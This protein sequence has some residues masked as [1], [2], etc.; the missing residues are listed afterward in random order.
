[1]SNTWFRL[2]FFRNLMYLIY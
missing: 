2:F 1:M